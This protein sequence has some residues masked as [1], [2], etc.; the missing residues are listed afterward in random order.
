[1]TSA[2]DAQFPLHGNPTTQSVRDNFQIAHNEISALQEQVASILL[3]LDP[4]SPLYQL[5]QSLEARIA[6]LENPS[7]ASP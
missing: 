3:T 2:I 7:S 5:I 6:A 4:G 1:M